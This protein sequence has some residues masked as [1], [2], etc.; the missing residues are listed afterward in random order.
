MKTTLLGSAG[1]RIAAGHLRAN[2][3]HI[4]EKNYRSRFGEIDVIAKKGGTVVFVEVKLR[5]GDQYGRAAEFVDRKK[6]EKLCKTA[7]QWLAQNGAEQAARFDI[8]EIYG[9]SGT[10]GYK[11]RQINHIENAFDSV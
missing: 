5:G 10:F 8:I 7:L 3:Y 1:E 2:G 4:V 9:Q 11:V 6:R